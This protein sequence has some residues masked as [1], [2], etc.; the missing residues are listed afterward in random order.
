[1]PSPRNPRVPRFAPEASITLMS[2]L[3]IFGRAVD[4][5]WTGEEIKAEIAPEPTDEDLANLAF[6]RV[7]GEAAH[8]PRGE[9]GDEHLTE[10]QILAA[11]SEQREISFAARRRWKA[12]TIRFMR[13][14]HQGMLRPS[15]MGDD[16]GVY[17]VPAHL[18]ASKHAEDLFDNGGYLEVRNGLLAVPRGLPQTDTATVLVN[19]D[20]LQRFIT[21]INEGSIPGV[22]P[23]VKADPYRT[24]LPGRPSIAHLIL[25]ELRRRFAAGEFNPTISAEAQ[26][27]RQWTISNH[28]EVSAPIDKSIENLIRPL[29]NALVRRTK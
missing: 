13:Y 27:L 9:V 4:P 19:G 22:A 28:P 14:L 3:D 15:A 5:A 25:A 10:H 21:A 23:E 2:A 11:L 7:T 29:Y 20:D 16:G 18:W 8:D 24:G 17:E 1:M 12:A 26:A 6:A